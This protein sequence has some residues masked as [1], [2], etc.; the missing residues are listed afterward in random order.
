MGRL[1]I[2]VVLMLL[3]CTALTA[4]AANMALDLM[5]S[6][7]YYQAIPRQGPLSEQ[8]TTIIN[9]P[10]NPIRVAQKRAVRIA[11]MLF[12]DENTIENKSLQ[13][14][15]RKRMRELGIDYRLDIYLDDANDNSDLSA[16]LKIASTPPDYIVMTKLGF[17][18]RRFL[19][20][21]LRTSKA[22][23]IL[24]D[25]ATPLR[26]WMNHPPLMYIGF[27]QKKAAKMLAS[28]LDRQLPSD[29]TISALVLPQ[30]YLSY[31]RCDLFLDEMLKYKRRISRVRVV[32]DDKKHAYEAARVFLNESPT[33]FIFSCSQNISEGVVAALEERS[34]KDTQT[35]AWG[36]SSNGIADLLNHKVRVNV[37][38][39]QDNLSIAVAEA[40]KL[41]L[42]GKNMPNLYVAHSTLMPAELD[43]DSLRLMVQQAYQYSVELWRQ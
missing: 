1:C 35:N 30:G 36:L 40:I 15:L 25:F 12:G 8:F 4:R 34:I 21:F 39:M 16:Y 13:M 11:L 2:F 42:E 10:P 41:D 20:H 24:Y 28:Y 9:S 23:V 3:G 19:E 29:T 17:V 7:D 22:K 32:A 31:T 26:H 38:F 14:A 33:D 18:Q 6:H 43:S 5:D 37:L 27:D